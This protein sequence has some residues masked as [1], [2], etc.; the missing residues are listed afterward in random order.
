[1][2]RITFGGAVRKQSSL[3]RSFQ[4]SPGQHSRCFTF[5][6]GR[7]TVD[8]CELKSS[9]VLVRLVEGGSVAE[10]LWVEDNDIG[11]TIDGQPAAIGEA[12]D[13]GRE[14]RA[15]TDRGGERQDVFLDRVFT[16]LAW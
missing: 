6:D 13:V 16:D 15:G 10:L 12:E 11:A 1:M 8:E 14:R 4:G 7:F 5:F 3:D 2:D 9:R